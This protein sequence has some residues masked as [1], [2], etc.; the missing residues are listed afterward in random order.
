MGDEPAFGRVARTIKP[1]TIS[2][3]QPS[4]FEG[5][6][7]DFSPLIGF[8]MAFNDWNIFAKTPFLL[9]F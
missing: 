2:G 4:V 3:A 7:F 8:L 1:E 6:A 5:G 9:C